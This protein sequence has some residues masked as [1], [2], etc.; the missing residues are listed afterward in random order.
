MH[1]ASEADDR[2]Q[3]RPLPI[4][5][6]LPEAVRCVLAG[7]CL[8][9]AAPPGSGK[10]T[11]LPPAL[12]DAGVR[13]EVWVLQP[14]RLAAL[15]AAGRVAEERGGRLGDEVG[16]QVRHE[17]RVGP[18]T[19]LRFVTE[20]VLVRR[21]LRHPALEGIGA[22]VLDE[23]HERSVEA[24]LAVAM[25]RE[26]RETLRED[27]G[28]VVMSATLDVE[29]IRSFLAAEVVTAPGEPYPVEVRYAERIDRRPLEIRVRDAVRVALQETGGDVLVFLPGVAEIAACVDA[30]G[31]ERE[32]E[33]VALHG[34]L[35]L[36]EQRR[37]VRPGIRRRVVCATNVAETS[38]TVPGVTAVVDSGLARILRH[39][40]GRG[41]DVLR[42]EQISRA[43]AEQ[44][45]GRAGRTGPGLCLR[46]WTAGEHRGRVQHDTPELRRVDVAGALLLARAFS[47]SSPFPWFEPPCPESVRRSE[48]LLVR[49]GALD[50]R[51]LLTELGREMAKL[52][53]HPRL[54]R[55]MIEAR[56]S[57]CAAAAAAV[58]AILS[59]RD[60]LRGRAAEDPSLASRIELL[61][62]LERRAFDARWAAAYEIDLRA[63]R[64]VARVRRQLAASCGARQDAAATHEVWRALLTAYPDRVA[65]LV[66]PG[67]D[68]VVLTD[69]QRARLP[70]RA[71]EEVDDLLV[72]PALQRS[73]RR[74]G[75]VSR[76][77]LLARVERSWLE[78]TL[79]PHLVREEDVE[80]DPERGRVVAVRRVRF[81]ELVLEETRGGPVDFERAR[82]CLSALV[83][84]D[85][86]RWT[87]GDTSLERLLGRL[88]WL[89][90][91]R[92]EFAAHTDEET[93]RGRAV[94]AALKPGLA[95]AD[96]AGRVD[97][98]RCL[99]ESLPGEVRAALAREA[100]ERVRLPSGRHALVDYASPSGP[101]VSVRIQELFGARSGPTLG[102]GGPAAVLRLLAPN[103][104]PVQ[105][106]RDLESFWN[107][108]YPTVR[109]ELARR[110]PKHDWPE[111]PRTAAPG[112][113]P[114][115]RR[116]S[117]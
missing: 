14:R 43:A 35:P 95:L 100:P 56:E 65:R 25:L 5:E 27:L 82:R 112:P 42:V 86:R 93:A 24:D 4:H 80:V 107:D 83:R 29:P 31:G 85:P 117:C 94:E 47:G 37:A 89:S 58:A 63:A 90:G 109:R 33:I 17:R 87:R 101:A 81:D 88:R 77:R 53:L 64:L 91:G 105:V 78:E 15:A 111:D 99:E 32:V 51:G 92:P 74:G 9:L 73:G 68:E 55:M 72:A 1:H 106:T 84:R 61:E 75:T 22:V 54:A 49:L 66:S 45:R 10:T 98:G 6:V 102:P 50:G 18:H 28:L 62:E 8:V 104:R 60:F 79:A 52:P 110:Y 70:Q 34:G 20:G 12:V 71:L 115:R 30:L 48:T 59:E 13:G 103:G 19:R 97:L 23:F 69:G 46:L 7:R 41:L 76:I 26:V 44:R 40:Q 36:D 108:T 113:G 2:S 38:V 39:D 67:A 16:Y 3:A 57:G 114:R 21:I 96:L 11:G 116:G